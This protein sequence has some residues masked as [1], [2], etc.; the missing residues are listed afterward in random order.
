MENEVVDV[1]GRSR[2]SSPESS[3][4]S[5]RS[6]SSSSVSSV[7]SHHSHS[8]SPEQPPAPPTPEDNDGWQTQGRLR[9]KKRPAVAATTTTEPAAP[10]T[11][12]PLPGD[13]GRLF[14]D[15]GGTKVYLSPEIT[16]E[17]RKQV[18]AAR[19]E[20]NNK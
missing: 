2:S 20:Q 4:P 8:S 6:R 1:E 13:G 17:V 19:A 14:A 5:H 9:K 11:P 7:S 12:M 15:F 18:A 3:V 10:T 16:R